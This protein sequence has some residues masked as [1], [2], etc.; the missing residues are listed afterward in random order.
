MIFVINHSTFKL[1]SLTA[2]AL[3]AFAGNSVLCKL[4][5]GEHLIDANT[6]TIIR[7]VSGAATL[8]FLFILTSNK[9]VITIFRYEK[10][11]YSQGG[12]LFVYAAFFSF[13]YILLDTASGA[14]LLFASVQFCMLFYQFWKG[15]KPKARELLGLTIAMTGFVYWMLPNSES[16]SVIGSIL[17][18]TSGIAWACYTLSGKS[19]QNAKLDTT[20]N[21]ILALTYLV[22]LLPLYFLHIKFHI[23][24]P[25]IFYGVLSG[26]VTSA[27]GYWVWYSVL[28]LMSVSSAAV[29]QLLVPIIAAVGGLIWNDEP[30]S[31]SFMVTCFMILT[32]IY[33]VVKEQG[34]N[35]VTS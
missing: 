27:I 29:L 33:L 24:L 3:L 22:L 31:Y 1:F 12:F 21:F 34:S 2:F 18:I 13:A 8:V 10:R 6:F 5:L 9:P 26:A 35:K 17:M 11:D 4:A 16:P 14:L 30:V 28:P 32:G 7:L 25:G 20:R 19:S 23:T 15:K